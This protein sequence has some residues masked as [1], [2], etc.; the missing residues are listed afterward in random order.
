MLDKK[1]VRKDWDRNQLVGMRGMRGIL[2]AHALRQRGC[3]AKM[4]SKH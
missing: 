4:Y 3:I 1:S 2:L